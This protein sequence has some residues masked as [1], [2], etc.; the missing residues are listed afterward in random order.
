MSFNR[1][2]TSLFQLGMLVVCVKLALMW[3]QD[4]KENGL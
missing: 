3:Y 2:I 1:L 4:Y